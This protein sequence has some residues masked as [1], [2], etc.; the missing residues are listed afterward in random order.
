MTKQNVVVA[1]AQAAINMTISV[2]VS[3]FTSAAQKPPAAPG[4]YFS[5]SRKK[6]L[7]LEINGGARI[8]A[9]VDSMRASSPTHI[10]STPS[11]EEEESSWIVSV[12]KKKKKF[13]NV[14]LLQISYF[15][16]FFFQK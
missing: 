4:G 12:P 5:I 9:W 14:F 8:N 6:F 1:D 2:S 15:F 3:N 16:V 11:L 10:K 7:N 13:T